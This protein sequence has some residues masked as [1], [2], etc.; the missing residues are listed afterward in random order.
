MKLTKE[1][2][3][4]IIKEEIEAVMDEAMLSPEQE[5][6]NKEYAKEF[7]FAK[8]LSPRE[9]EVYK[10]DPKAYKEKL[11]AIRKNTQK[12]KDIDNAIQLAYYGGDQSLA[13]TAAD[14]TMYLKRDYP[15]ITEDDVRYYAQ[16]AGIK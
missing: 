4:Q 16:M 2:L 7:A 5:K 10:K 3:K 1:T 15:D 9:R 14:A 11:A 13:T 12:R 8:S 6:R